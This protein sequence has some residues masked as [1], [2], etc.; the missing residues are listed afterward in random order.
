[1]HPSAFDSERDEDW[2]LQE[3]NYVAFFIKLPVFECDKY[4]N[5]CLHLF[6]KKNISLFLDDGMTCCA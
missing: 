5:A 2:M 1:M 6:L 3:A 4:I